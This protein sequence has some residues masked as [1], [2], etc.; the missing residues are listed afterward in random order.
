MY[1]LNIYLSFFLKKN[2]AVLKLPRLRSCCRSY[3][4]LTTQTVY[5][6]V[7]QFK[8]VCIIPELVLKYLHFS[9]VSGLMEYPMK[10]TNQFFPGRF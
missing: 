10:E 4:R 9:S 6:A 2:G 3:V 8:S 7:E 1:F 5:L